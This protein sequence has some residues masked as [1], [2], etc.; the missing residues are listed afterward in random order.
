MSSAIDIDG[1]AACLPVRAE[2]WGATPRDV[3]KAV[4]SATSAPSRRGWD[5]TRI[6]ELAGAQCPIDAS[7]PAPRSLAVEAGSGWAYAVYPVR[8]DG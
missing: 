4:D 1:A 7:K 6:D 3:Q 8:A 5:F 2:V